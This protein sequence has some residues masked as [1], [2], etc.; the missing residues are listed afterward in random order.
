MKLSFPDFLETDCMYFGLCGRLE[1][2]SVEILHRI[3]GGPNELAAQLDTDKGSGIVVVFL[4]GE[5]DAHVHLDVLNKDKVPTE[6]LPKDL[7]K[8]EE[9]EALLD[10]LANLKIRSFVYAHFTRSWDKL[11]PSSFIRGLSVAAKTEGVE[12]K[13]EAATFRLKGIAVRKIKWNLVEDKNEV[14][15]HLSMAQRARTFDADYVA[16][17]FCEV[18][19]A[20]RSFVLR[21]TDDGESSS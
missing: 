5:H 13:L 17:G 10:E 9:L 19:A 15:V 21:E 16:K 2:P 12:L 1:E 20:Y 7:V 3:R 18:D 11:S 4:G 8:P 6:N 14:H